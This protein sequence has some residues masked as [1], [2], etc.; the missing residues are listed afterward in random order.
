[1]DPAR[2]LKIARPKTLVVLSLDRIADVVVSPPVS[3]PWA[4]SLRE[5]LR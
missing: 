3:L 4:F 5:A 2:E 1:M